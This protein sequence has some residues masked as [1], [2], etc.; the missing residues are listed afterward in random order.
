M[1]EPN[2]KSTVELTF[3]E[4]A[5]IV[6]EKDESGLT[7]DKYLDKL[8]SEA[9]AAA[10]KLEI[11]QSVVDTCEATKTRKSRKDRGV[12]RKKNGNATATT[13]EAVP[14]PEP[15]S[16]SSPDPTAPAGTDPPTR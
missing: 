10:R 7:F 2:E 14:H 1:A 9:I 5:A 16:P 11:A 15:V 4:M 8:E 3:I 13:G 6:K 12:P